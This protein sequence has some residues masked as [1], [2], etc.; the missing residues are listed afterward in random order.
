MKLTRLESTT[1]RPTQE[2][3]ERARHAVEERIRRV[4]ALEGTEAD[5][6]RSLLQELAEF[7]T[8]AIAPFDRGE[9]V[10]QEA[11]DVA[12]QL[13]ALGSAADDLIMPASLTAS[14]VHID[15]AA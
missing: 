4:E 2:S 3:L 11:R 8:A 15:D 6:Q 9:Q 13:S 1:Q 5:R 14:V 10:L 12:A 7:Q